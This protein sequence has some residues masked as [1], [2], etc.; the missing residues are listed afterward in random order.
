LSKVLGTILRQTQGEITHPMNQIRRIYGKPGLF[1]Y[2][3]LWEY[4]YREVEYFDTDRIMKSLQS[5][6]AAYFD[7]KT[8]QVKIRYHYWFLSSN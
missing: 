1:F 5:I 6:G 4:Q 8:F 2:K 3:N 7:Y